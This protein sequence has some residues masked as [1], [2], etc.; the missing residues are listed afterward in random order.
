MSFPP[1]ISSVGTEELVILVTRMGLEEGR[2]LGYHD[3]QDNTAGKEIYRSAL[4]RLLKVNLRC[5]VAL[6]A[7]S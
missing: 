1:Y 4:V 5:H 7:E 6:S 2:M 3:E